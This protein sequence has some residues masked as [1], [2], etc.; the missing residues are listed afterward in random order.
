MNKYY[1]KEII[2]KEEL[3][4]EPVTEETTELLSDDEFNTVKDFKQFSKISLDSRDSISSKKSSAKIP[5]KIKDMKYIITNL[6]DEDLKILVKILLGNRYNEFI[7]ILK[8][9]E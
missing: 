4:E 5:D 2:L 6:K 8:G 1:N 7:E 3:K 9:G